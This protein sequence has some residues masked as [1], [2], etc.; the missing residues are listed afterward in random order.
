[1]N[2]YTIS[3]LAA[4]AGVSTSVVRDYER[5]G[6]L[7]PCRCTPAGYR[8]YDRRALERLR[9]ALD[10]KAAGIPLATLAELRRAQQEGDRVGINAVLREIHTALERHE[11]AIV[12]FR[13]RLAGIG[14]AEDLPT[15]TA[16]Q[17]RS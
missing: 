6:L 13:E 10:A 5:R 1:M 7:C 3:K 4:D 17:G 12:R 14:M 2:T 8:I 11:N 15:I 16:A 9:L